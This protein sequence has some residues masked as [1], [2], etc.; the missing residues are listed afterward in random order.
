MNLTATNIEYVRLFYYTHLKEKLI[1]QQP[2]IFE[3]I[4]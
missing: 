1:L 3:N 2:E 4:I